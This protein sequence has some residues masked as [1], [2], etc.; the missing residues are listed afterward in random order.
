MYGASIRGCVLVTCHMLLANEQVMSSC[1]MPRLTHL[2][3][4]VCISGKGC[5]RKPSN[6]AAGEPL[7]EKTASRKQ[8]S[9]C[10]DVCGGSLSLCTPATRAR[11][12]RAAMRRSED[13]GCQHVAS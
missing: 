3:A 6:A 1:D 12:C 4:A 2:K 9:A 8:P 13:P 10:S 11:A 5:L 7:A